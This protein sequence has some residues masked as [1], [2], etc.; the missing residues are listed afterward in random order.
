MT[1]AEARPP[2]KPARRP[3]TIRVPAGTDEVMCDGGLGALGHP[4]VWYSFDGRDKCECHYCDR[5]F[6]K[7]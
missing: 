3:E 1:T 5:V 6:L 4:A 7:D 2:A